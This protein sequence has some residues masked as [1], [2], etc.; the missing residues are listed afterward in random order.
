MADQADRGQSTLSTAIFLH[1]PPSC[2]NTNSVLPTEEASAAGCPTEAFLCFFPEEEKT[3]NDTAATR[4][5]KNF[6]FTIFSEY[7]PIDAIK[8]TDETSS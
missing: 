6:S 3:K 5:K 2:S 8:Q 4:S 7:V 1:L